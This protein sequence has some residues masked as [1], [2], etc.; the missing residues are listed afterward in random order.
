[1]GYSSDGGTVNR[2]LTKYFEENNIDT[3]S[4]KTKKNP[5]YTK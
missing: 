1:L 2:V 3:S 4:L 5:V